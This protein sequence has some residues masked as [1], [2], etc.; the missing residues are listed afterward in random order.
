ME[1]IEEYSCEDKLE[2]LEAE[3]EAFKDAVKA[4]IYQIED[5]GLNVDSYLFKEIKAELGMY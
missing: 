2:H 3:F 4:L 1:T 5:G